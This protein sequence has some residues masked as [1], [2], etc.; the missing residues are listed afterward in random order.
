MHKLMTFKQNPALRRALHCTVLAAA[1]F[2]FSGASDPS[3]RFNELGHQLMCICSCSQILLEC[4]HVGCPDSDG[5]RNELM[6][7]I[8]RGDSDS[9]VE[10]AFVQKYGPTVLA[11]PTTTGFD[12]TAWIMPFVVLLAGIG[13][14]VYI[15]RAWKNRP[16]PAIA[17]GLTAVPGAELDE[18]REQAR[19]ETDL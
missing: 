12:R 16:A 5:M 13:L 1:V 3:T 6:A 18:F 10:Q 9:L 8:S 15:V 7:A 17:D 4:N 14:L 11:A 2:A 19:K